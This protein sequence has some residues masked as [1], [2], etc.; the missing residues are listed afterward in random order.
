MSKA[1]QHAALP[2]NATEAGSAAILRAALEAFEAEGFH[3]TS[4]RAI[5]RRAGVS[6]ALIYYHY[7]SKE[8]ILRTL[9]LRVTDDLHADLLT[10]CEAAGPLPADRLAALVR[11]HV[12]FHTHRQAESFVANTELRSLDAKNRAEVVRSRDAIAGLFKRTIADGLA[13]GDFA[14]R[15]PDEATL[16][17]LSMCTSVADWYR[18]DGAKTP[19]QIAEDYVT[20]ALDLLRHPR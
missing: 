18:T 3:G 19:D 1:Q 5:A 12:S 8:E 14:T 2:D 4:I 17:I 13:R 10:A 15:S 7:P 16:A 6:I 11:V 20:F 9:M